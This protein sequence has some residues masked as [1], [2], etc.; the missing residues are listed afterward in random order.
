MGATMTNDIERLRRVSDEAQ[1][2]AHDAFS[3][4]QRAQLDLDYKGKMFAAGGRV[5]GREITSTEV[6][7]MRA[8]VRDLQAAYE[9]AEVAELEASNA[10]LD[11]LRR[12]AAELTR[13]EVAG[14]DPHL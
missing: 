7:G 8:M 2:A 12:Q 6:Q 11:A 14:F 1:H 13:A 4:W 10:Y 3:A 9:R 5:F